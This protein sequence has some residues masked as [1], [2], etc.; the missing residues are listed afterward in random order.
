MSGIKFIYIA[1]GEEIFKV[2]HPKVG[3][4]YK[5]IKELSNQNVLKV[6]MYYETKDRKPHQLITV[7]FD[8]I[9]LDSGG[10]YELNDEEVN[11]RLQNAFHFMYTTPQE[12]ANREEP[13]EL[14]LAPSIP[15]TKEK[16]ALYD[17]L[18]SKFPLL[19]KDAPMIVEKNIRALKKIHQDKINMIKEAL[20]LRGKIY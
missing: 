12:M 3:K 20:K 2:A 17:Y 14:P 4:K 9:R 18:N 11:K 5:G 1:R 8:R 19:G 7:E 15:S 10:A 16:I 6:M 13:F